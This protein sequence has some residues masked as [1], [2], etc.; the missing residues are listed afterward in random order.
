MENKLAIIGIYVADGTAVE[1]VNAIL[2]EFGDYVVGRMGIPYRDRG[3]SVISLIVDAPPDVINTVT[4]KLG[5]LSGV[6]A[7]TMLAKL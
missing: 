7:K 5:F 4:G 2:H 1:R 3:V 6:T